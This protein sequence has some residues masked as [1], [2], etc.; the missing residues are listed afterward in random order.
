ME[1]E[2]AI[3]KVIKI[4]AGCACATAAASVWLSIYLDFFV[5]FPIWICIIVGIASISIILGV[6]MRKINRFRKS[7]I[8]LL[9]SAQQ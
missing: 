6:K 4:I 9:E 2:L 3:L 7:I 5:K 1:R 8:K